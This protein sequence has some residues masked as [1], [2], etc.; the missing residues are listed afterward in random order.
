MFEQLFKSDPIIA[1][2]KAAPYAAERER[3]LKCLA[4][5]GY[6]INLG[7]EKA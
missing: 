5:Q 2:H 6:R 4:D 1:R 3:Y 7:T